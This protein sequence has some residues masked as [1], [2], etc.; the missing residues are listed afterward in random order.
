MAWKT[1]SSI[2]ADG[3]DELLGNTD[4]PVLVDFW[5]P[6]C[7][8]CRA[9]EPALGK[10]VENMNDRVEFGK[11]NIDRNQELAMRYNVRSIPTLLVFKGQEE[12]L[13][14]NA[15]HYSAEQ[16]QSELEAVCNG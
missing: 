2:N 9:M 1:V 11:V 4:A 5:A 7:A 12:V 15:G 3:F 6:W 16:L 10:V 8:P 13:R 14:L